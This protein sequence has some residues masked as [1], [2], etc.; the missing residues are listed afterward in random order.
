MKLKKTLAAILAGL[1]LTSASATTVAALEPFGHGLPMR[2]W[3]T[4]DPNYRFSDAYKTSVWYENF[5]DLALT[6]NERNNVLRIAVSQLG[7]HEGNSAADFDGMN[8]S[9]SGNYIEYARLLIPHYNDNAYEWCACFVN[10]CLNQA[11]FDKA[12]SEIGCWKW[13]GELKDMDMWQDSAAY[14]GAYTPK[15]ADF[16]FFNW[17]HAET[18]NRASGHIGYVLYTT[19]T[20]VFTIEG[21]ADNNVTV[22][23]YEL[24]DPC[25]IGYGTPPYDEGD[26]PTLDY[27]YAEGMPRGQYVVNSYNAALKEA[28]GATGRVCTVPAGAQVTLHEVEGDYARVTYGDREGYLPRGCLYLLI[29]AVGEDTLTFDANGGEGAPEAV[30]VP[31]G[32]VA[33][34]ADGAPTLEGDTFLGWSTVPYNVK[35]DFRPGESVTLTGDTTLY[36]VWEKRSLELAQQAAA[37]GLAPEYERPDSIQNSGALLMGTLDPSLFTDCGDTEV[38]TAE[39]EAAGKVLSFVSTAASSDPFVT[40]PYGALMDTLRLAPVDGVEVRFVILRVKDVSMNNLAMELLFN[41]NTCKATALLALSED[42][43][44]AVFDLTDAGFDGE[45]SS[46]RIDWEKAADEAGNTMLLSEIYFASSEAVRDAIL[47]GKYVYPPQELLAPETESA[48][49]APTE[50][51]TPSVTEKDTDPETKAPEAGC[52]ATLGLSAPAGLLVACAAFVILGRKK[53]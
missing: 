39:D 16:I 43:Q 9:G 24:D 53:D 25:V 35:V 36:A 17:N 2:K 10:W 26:E 48:T 29:P 12:S 14:R 27:A 7:Y 52:S 30:T 4:N 32:E 15:P 5:T 41:G 42:W 44:Y 18:G 40:L 21:N 28:P 47:E 13:V 11:H 46:L 6:D 34:L 45:L 1:L 31:I 38:R 8:T 49:D 50:P 22:R 23:S 33:I 3:L 51:V 37:E 19:D 20:H